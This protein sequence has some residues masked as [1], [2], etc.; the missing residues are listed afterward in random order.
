LIRLEVEHRKELEKTEHEL[1]R[2]DRELE[3]SLKTAKKALKRRLKKEKLKLIK[4]GTKKLDPELIEEKQEGRFLERVH[5]IYGDDVLV[6]KQY[7]S[8]SENE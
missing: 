2:K 7:S 3:C 5:N 4:E 6:K 8:S 1:R